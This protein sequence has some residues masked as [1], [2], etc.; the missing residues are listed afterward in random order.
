MGVP[1]Y[2]GS[3][4]AALDLCR[5]VKAARPGIRVIGGG[6]LM[7]ARYGPLL[8]TGAIDFGVIG[9][10]ELAALEI[11]SSPEGVPENLDSIAFV[12]NGRV[13]YNGNRR[14]VENLDELPFTDYSLI[15]MRP[16]F[17]MHDRLSVPR[18]VFM[19]TSR[20]CAYK[21]TF[22]ASPNLWPGRVR[23]YSPARV[24][25]EM[26]RHRNAFGEINIGFLDDSFLADKKWLAE[27]FD[28]VKKTGATY[29]CIGR[30][31]HIGPEEAGLLAATGCRFVSMGVESGSARVQA[32]I[33]KRLDLSRVR[34]AVSLLSAKKI[35]CRCFFMTG[36]PG[37][38]VGEMAETVN[39]AVDL[40]KAGMTDCT[41]FITNLYA[42]TELSARYDESL[43]R[44]KIYRCGADA[45]QEPSA[46]VSSE[47]LRRYS[48][49]PDA[50]LNEFL[51]REALVGLVKLAYAKIEKCEY[52]SVSEIEALAGAGEGGDAA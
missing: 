1:F 17:E 19:T 28:G 45:S 35:Y 24:L 49:V 36:F 5:R 31:D 11:A 27:F 16:Y 30:A 20:G 37:E 22:C 34:S 3:Q 18:S 32:L 15:D 23:R 4:D 39:L 13:E 43:W 51:D 38:T 52:I 50:D 40:K 25:D 9:E 46:D 26:S 47:K 10:G 48:S 6:P 7:T 21:C 12:K 8:E 41:F 33:K 14:H 29:S 44:S 42:G 2:Q